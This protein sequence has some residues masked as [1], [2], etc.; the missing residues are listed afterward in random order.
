MANWAGAR[1][2][3]LAPRAMWRGGVAPATT[4]A[5]A[6]RSVCDTTKAHTHCPRQPKPTDFDRRLSLFVRQ[7]KDSAMHRAATVV[8]AAR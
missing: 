2:R 5:A 1:A 3:A 4:V 7:K 6:S 8:L